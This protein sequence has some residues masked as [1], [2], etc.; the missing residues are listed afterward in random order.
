MLD[1]RRLRILQH[2]AAYGTVAATAEALHLTAPAISQHLAALEREAGTPV[3]EKHGR[4]LRLTATG[5]LL[6]AHAEIILAELAAAESGLAALRSGRRGVVR[7]AAFAS[8]ARVLLPRVWRRLAGRDEALTV[9]LAV[10]EPHEALDELRK[11]GTDLAL[12]H[13]YTVLPRSFPAGCEQTVLMEEPVL[14]ALHPSCAG[15]LGL[16]AG[17]SA[18]LTRLAHLPWLV[19]G[20]ET[21]CYEMIQRACGAAGFVPDVRARSSDFSVL[22]ALVAAGA[23]AA[24][25][26]RMALPE[27]TA[28]L[29]LHPLVRPVSRTVFTVSRAGTSR[30]PDLRQVVELVREAAAALDARVPQPRRSGA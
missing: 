2:L 4:T 5:E 25:V 6:V 27:S 16:A 29:S 13:S 7:V 28:G 17:E 9:R 11:R 23:G 30:H 24:L 18:D 21:S 8:A 12:V 1:V 14:L 22:T 20:P 26:P 19:P 10:Q 3:V 15:Q